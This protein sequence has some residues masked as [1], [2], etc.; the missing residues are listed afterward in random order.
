MVENDR[1]PDLNELID[2]GASGQVNIP[3]KSR[4]ISSLQLKEENSK[5]PHRRII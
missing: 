4:I 5:R 3:S 2:Y 1:D